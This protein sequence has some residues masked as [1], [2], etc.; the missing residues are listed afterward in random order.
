MKNRTEEHS[1]P[2]KGLLPTVPETK[3][4]IILLAD[5]A[6]RDHLQQKPLRLLPTFFFERGG[7]LL[8]SRWL[9]ISGDSLSVPQTQSS[10]GLLS[11]LLA[12]AYRGR[13]TSNSSRFPYLL[14]EMLPFRFLPFGKILVEATYSYKV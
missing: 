2:R 14:V 6:A 7:G 13:S 11:T 3:A 8:C 1:L 10:I 5:F 4:G 9:A 12:F